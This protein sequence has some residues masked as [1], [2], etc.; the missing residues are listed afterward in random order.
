MIQPT[1]ENPTGTIKVTSPRGRKRKNTYS[2]GGAFQASPVFNNVMPGTYQVTVKGADECVSSA[3]VV[4]ITEPLAPAAPDVSVIQPTCEN[5][6]GTIKVTSPQ[7]RKR[8]NTYSI[9]GA[10]QASPVFNNVMPG[11]YQ[12]TVKGADNCVSLAKVVVITEPLA[13]AAPEVSVI[14]PTCEVSTGT[15]KVTSPL[16]RKRKYTYSIGGAFQTSPVF[17]NVMPGTY[18]VTVKGADNCVSLAKVVVIKEPLT[19]AA[20]E[21]SVIQPTCEVPTGNIKVN[22]PRGR[23]YTYSIGGAF[24]TSPVF[25]QV[26]PGKYNVR[27]KGEDNCVSMAKVVVIEQPK[28]KC[29]VIAKAKPVV[30]LKL[31]SQGKATL[32]TAMADNGSEASCDNLILE[33]SKRN[34]TCED[35]GKTTVKLIA[36]DSKGNRSVTEFTVV[37]VD[38]SKPKIKVAKKAFVWMM[39]KGDTFT[40]PDFRDRVEV[41]D[42]CGYELTQYPAPGTKFRKSENI[43]VR[44]EAKDPSGNRAT[45]NFRF[46]LLVFKCKVTKKN[47]RID[48][49]SELSD[50]LVVPWNT[51]FNKVIS[52]GVIFEE[53]NDPE[54]INSLKWQMN[55]YNPLR[56]D[57]YRITATMDNE[58]FEGW[59]NSIDIPVIVLDKPLAE[60]IMLSKNKVSIKVQSGEIIG[61]LNTLDPVD[62]IHTYSMDEHPDF[63]IDRN[64]LIWKGAGIPE[65]QMTVTV[66]ST[67]RAGQTISRELTLLRELARGEILIYPNPAT[68]ETNLLVQL[69]S[70]GTVGIRIFDAAGRLVYEEQVHQEG[71]FVHNIDLK[72]LSSGMYQVIVQSGKEVMTG[73][74]VKK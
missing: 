41:S 46:N 73:R 45:D 23:K 25:S 60:D 57:L 9:G 18:Q 65:E 55:D 2:I 10:F 66:H 37:V 68:Q 29:E 3:T 51:A 48:E 21:V 70:A 20:P 42:N 40:M 50:M 15:I 35:I 56:P 6:T 74:L 30:I 17:N 72:D 13:P 33:L 58:G 39:K 19:P 26:L 63:F 52:E 11:T 22:S 49:E 62:N 31:N 12:V 43:F 36:R 53:G 7:G 28:C 47:G 71:N 44:F 54:Y 64:V 8:K 34:F 32:T 69:S 59:D 24:Q 5:P 1:C 27:V 38:E 14:Q 16:G 61:S 67:D 4:V